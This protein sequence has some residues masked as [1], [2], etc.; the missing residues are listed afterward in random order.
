M[1]KFVITSKR[2]KGKVEALYN[3][4]TKLVRIEF[5][6]VELND[7]GINWL[8]H[9]IPASQEELHDRFKETGIDVTEEDIEVTFEEFWR[10]YPYKRNRHIASDQW[11]KLTTREQ[12]AAFIGAIEYR[13]FLERKQWQNPM[14][15]DAWLKKAQYRNDWKNL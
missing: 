2:F 12:Y 3:L 9:R 4:D 15:A 10:E 11:L 5:G 1:R 14:I 13:K 8:K 6:A 7:D